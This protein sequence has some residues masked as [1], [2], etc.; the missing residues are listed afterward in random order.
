M[1]QR[2]LLFSDGPPVIPIGMDA[3]RMWDC[4]A[5]QRIGARAYMPSTRDRSGGNEAACAS[6]YVYKERE[7]F[8]VVEHVEGPGVLYFWRANHWHGSPWHYETDGEDHVVTETGTND[9]IAARKTQY[10]K[11][12]PSRFDPEHLFHPPLAWTWTTTHGADLNWTPIPFETSFRMAYGRTF[13][14]TGYG[15]YHRYLPGAEL[16]QPLQTYDWQTPPPNDVERL[17]NAAGTD[18]APPAG[19]ANVTQ[20]A[21][22][23][24]LSC[25]E[26]VTLIELDDAPATIRALQLSAPAE[27]AVDLGSAW[28]R[29]TWDDRKHPSVD[30]PLALFFGAGNLY[31]RDGREYLVK[32]LP[33]N[34]R[35]ADD[36]VHLACYFPM[37][38][39]RSAKIELIGRSAR[40]IDDVRFAIRTQPYTGPVN[41]VGYFHATY[42]D[43]PIPEKGKDVLLLD[44]RQVEGGGDWSGSFVGTSFIFTQQGYLP[45]LE[46]IPRFFFDD[47][48]APQACGTGTEEWGGG[49][50]YWGGRNMT[51]PLAGHPCGHNEPP[52]AIN[53]FNGKEMKH[54]ANPMDLVHSAYRFLLAD[55]MPFGRNAVIGLEHGGENETNEHYEAVTYWYGLPEASLIPTDTL[56]IGDMESEK[57]HDYRVSEGTVPVEVVSR[58]ERGVDHLEGKEIYPAHAETE[59]HHTSTSEFTLKLESTNLGVMLRRTFDYLYPNQRAEVFVADAGSDDWAPVGV[60]FTPGSNTCV[61]SEPASGSREP[62]AEI[63]PPGNEERTVNRRF[64]QSEFLI[65]REH[66]EG[67]DAIRIRIRFSP[68]DIDVWPD[69]PFPE[70]SAWSEIRY[71]AYCYVMPKPHI[72]P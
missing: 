1:A 62:E 47:A 38:F 54:C 66:T 19:E 70:Q 55:L 49:G 20:H 71:D 42:A 56:D 2:D 46:G 63:A 53:P 36:R 34:I 22:T 50:D 25:G 27:Y 58:F 6:H 5:Q 57:P 39:F 3:Y 72:E 23:V 14:G 28:I 29:I 35:F 52:K 48:L 10:N 4:W 43:H 8:S 16:S 65:G 67:R 32:A 17:L 33:M 68:V 44:T 12:S 21:E 24:R 13:Y 45:T 11:P 7:D 60:W 30:A 61:F 15:I 64:N 31:N 69:H 37:P 18:I 41:H 59:R 51:L 40:A 9:P 26:S